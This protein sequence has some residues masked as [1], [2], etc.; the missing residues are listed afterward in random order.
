[1]AEEKAGVKA[2]LMADG[3]DAGAEAD[4]LEGSAEVV[5]VAV[6]GA[7]DEHGRVFMILSSS[8][9]SGKIIYLGGGHPDRDNNE[10]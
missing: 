1:M 3:A 9:N 6:E 4:V 10:T 7:A 5:V 2:D 8:F